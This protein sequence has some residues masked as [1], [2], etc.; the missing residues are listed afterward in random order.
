MP[1]KKPRAPEPKTEKCPNCGELFTKKGLPGH[2]AFTHGGGASAGEKKEAKPAAAERKPADD[3]GSGPGDRERDEPSD[4]D[5]FL[6][7]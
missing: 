6:F 4:Y 1:N 5:Q 2:I 7:D 3:A